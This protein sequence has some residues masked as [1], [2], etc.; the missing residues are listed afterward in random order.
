MVKH[1]MPR[2]VDGILQFKLKSK[3]AVWIK[4]PK[5]CGKS[6]TAE[7]FAKTVIRMQDEESRE[8]NIALARMSPAD[9]LKGDTP[10]LID[11]WQ[12]VPSIWNQI[13]VEVDRRD[14]FG[15]FL[16]TG[17][18]QPADADDPDKHSGTGRITTLT[19]RPMSLYESGESDGSV[20]LEQMFKGT[21]PAGRCDTELR[22][23]AFYTARG[24]WPK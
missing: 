3:G 19:M 5:W 20:S 23:Y 24:G 4:G 12:V 18:K 8:Q 10:L 17:S 9:F 2:I 22:D 6:T 7:Q 15:Q 21:C 14:E 13:R 11:E 16:L 1:Y